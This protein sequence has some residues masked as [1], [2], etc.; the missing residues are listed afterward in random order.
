MNAPQNIV[1]E[2]RDGRFTRWF[3][4]LGWMGLLICLPMLMALAVSRRDYF[5]T[6]DGIQEK[7]VAGSPTAAPKIAVIDVSGVIM[8]GDGFVKKQIN[9]IRKDDAVK[10]V[11]LR[12]DSPGGTVTGS[13]YIYH[14]LVELRKDRKL[15]MVVSMGSMAASG[16]YYIAMAVGD[17]EKSIF[18]EPT[19]TTGSIGVIIPHYDVSG[20]LSRFDIRDDS[21]VSHDRK[22]LLSMTRRATEDDRKI[23]KSYVD[24][25][26]DHFKQIVRSGRPLYRDEPDK[27]DQLATGEIFTAKRAKELGLVDEIGFVEDATARVMELAGLEAD[28]VRVVT[29]RAPMSMLQAVGVAKAQSLD[30]GSTWVAPFVPRAYYLLTTLPPFLGTNLL[31]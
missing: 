5:D 12:I 30:D 4:W 10:G 22:Q 13:D 27:L 7:F 28:K 19:T 3:A 1:I 2:Q 18:A 16:G 9:R 15:P 20:L 11:V 24:D 21:I 17:Q 26:F 29:Y 31:R 6:T 23:L 25:S 14:H 8:E